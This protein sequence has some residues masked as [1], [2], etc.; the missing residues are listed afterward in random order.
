VDLTKASGIRPKAQGL[1][2][3]QGQGIRLVWQS[4]GESVPELAIGIFVLGSLLLKA[5]AIFAIVYF[6]A[7]LAIRH[8]RRIPS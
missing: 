8:E 7:R 2:Q 1:V 4:G 5:I 3:E 6:G